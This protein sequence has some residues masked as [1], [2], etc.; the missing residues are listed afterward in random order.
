MIHVYQRDSQKFDDT[1]VP[2]GKSEAVNRRTE[3]TIAKK[4]KNKRTNNDL[5][6]TTL[7]TKDWAKQTPLKTED[8]LGAL[9]G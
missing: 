7:K 2:K 5:Q 1:C 9:E 4:K 3:N 6:N 8:D